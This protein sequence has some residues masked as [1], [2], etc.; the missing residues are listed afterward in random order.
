MIE[1]TKLIFYILISKKKLKNKYS[2]LL[3]FAHSFGYALSF[4]YAFKISKKIQYIY[5]RLFISCLNFIILHDK[6]V[7]SLRF[8]SKFLKFKVLPVILPKFSNFRYF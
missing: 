6:I 8:F 1:K 5:D 7:Q 3:Q 4:S 2:H